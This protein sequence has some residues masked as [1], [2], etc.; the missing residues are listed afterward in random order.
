MGPLVFLEGSLNGC[1]YSHLVANNFV[2]FYENTLLIDTIFQQ[3]NASCHR[4]REVLK[5]VE[6]E[7]AN[8][9]DWPAQSPD[10]NIIENVW[11]FIKQQLRN[12]NSANL[13]ELRQNIRDIWFNTSVSYTRKLFD[14]M[15]A[16]IKAKKHLSNKVLI[17]WFIFYLLYRGLFRLS[18][19]FEYN[20]LFFS[21]F[22]VLEGIIVKTVYFL[23]SRSKTKEKIKLQYFTIA[24]SFNLE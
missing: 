20:F 10:L 21:C 23:L 15:P 19:K 6:T 9:L 8:L 3:D 22:L 4:S 7:M 17:H 18:F 14:S 12:R 5:F 11:D 1:N 24:F 2:P 13:T 16:R